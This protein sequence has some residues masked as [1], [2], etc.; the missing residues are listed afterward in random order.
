MARTID[1]I[2]NDLVAQKNSTPAL[3]SLTSSSATAIWK[4]LL[5]VVAFAIHV[6][7]ALWDEYRKEVNTAIDEMIPHRPKWYRDKALSF[8]KDKTL[9]PDTDRYDTT[10]MTE[11]DIEAARVVKHATANESN[12]S[13]LLVIKVAGVDPEDSSKRAPI[14][15]EEAVQL[16]AYLQEIKDAGVRISLV[17]EAAD[18]FRCEVNIYYDPTK[19]PLTVQNDCETA[20]KDYVENLP[21]NGEFSNMAL[22]DTLQ[23]VDGVKIADLVVSESAPAAT[24]TF[25]PLH[26]SVAPTAGYFHVANINLNMN[27]HSL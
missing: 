17:N 26:A 25:A 15:P 4:L 8:M 10:G 23:T 3:N 2:F 11:E 7:E 5:Y 19:D 13:S 27:A 1:T 12:Q 6:H 9:I 22:I 14:Q 21:F 20:I 16:T 18:E 24:S